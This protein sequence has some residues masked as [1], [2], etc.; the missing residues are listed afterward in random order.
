MPPRLVNSLVSHP[1]P[2]LLPRAGGAFLWLLRRASGPRPF[3]I[4]PPSKRASWTPSSGPVSLQP[5]DKCIKQR[6]QQG[7]APKDGK[8]LIHTALQRAG[9][10]V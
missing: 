2:R 6:A 5:R 8:R 1:E 7:D 4:P 10:V 3:V 9:F